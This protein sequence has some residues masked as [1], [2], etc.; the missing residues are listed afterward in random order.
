[1]D[2]LLTGQREEE[3]KQKEMKEKLKIYLEKK[4]KDESERRKN[5]KPAFK[6]GVVHHTNFNLVSLVLH[7]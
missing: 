7:S 3:A 5:A 2:D 6:V 4:K 1:M